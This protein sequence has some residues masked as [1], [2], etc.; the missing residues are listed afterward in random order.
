MLRVVKWSYGKEQGT[1]SEQGKRKGKRKGHGKSRH[2]AA[3]ENVIVH[4]D[5]RI[6]HSSLNSS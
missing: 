5:C 6:S 3:T 1:H 2:Q 4:L